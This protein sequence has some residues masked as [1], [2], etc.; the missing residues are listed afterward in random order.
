MVSDPGGIR[1]SPVI[2]R[3][4]RLDRADCLPEPLTRVVLAGVVQAQAPGRHPT[5][6]QGVPSPPRED[7][8]TAGE[9]FT[10]GM[11]DVIPRRLGRSSVNEPL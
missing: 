6:S 9:W 11:T 1:S 8:G 10:V 3:P 2:H 5:E 7:I 4:G